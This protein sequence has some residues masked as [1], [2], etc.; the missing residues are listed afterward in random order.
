MLR[1]APSWDESLSTL[2]VLICKAQE[3]IRGWAGTKDCRVDMP[4]T[5]WAASE[6]RAGLGTP[7]RVLAIRLT[8]WVFVTIDLRFKQSWP[9]K[10]RISTKRSVRLLDRRRKT[11]R[12]MLW[13]IRMCFVGPSHHQWTS[14]HQG[15]LE[16]SWTWFDLFS[17]VEKVIYAERF[18]KLCMFSC[19]D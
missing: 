15:P 19:N 12:L 7:F 2:D 3:P 18:V 9:R 6:L 16:S 5:R 1:I 17:Y 13:C 8:P 10:F 4:F 14:N 11:Q